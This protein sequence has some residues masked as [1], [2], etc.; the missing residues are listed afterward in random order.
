MRYLTYILLSLLFLNSTL[1]AYAGDDPLVK[2]ETTIEEL[3][4]FFYELDER[5]YFV[6]LTGLMK[7]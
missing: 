6:I 1:M 7:S 3:P 2:V 4:G 5:L